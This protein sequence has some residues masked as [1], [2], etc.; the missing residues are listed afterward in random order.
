MG[1]WDRDIANVGSRGDPM[2]DEVCIADAMGIASPPTRNDLIRYMLSQPLQQK[3]MK[4][5]TAKKK[6]NIVQKRR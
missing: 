6:E 5:K 4:A 2:G 1:G 3:I